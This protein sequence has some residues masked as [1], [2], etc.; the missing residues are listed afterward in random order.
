MGASWCNARAL[1]LMKH[2]GVNLVMDQM[3]SAGYVG[4]VGGFVLVEAED[5][6][7]WSSQVEQDNRYL[8]EMSYI[9]MLEPSSAQEAKDMVKDAFQLSEDYKQ[10]FIIRSTTRVG[11]ARGDVKLGEIRKT[12][13][14]TS[15]TKDPT[16][17]ILLPANSRKL[18]KAM[19]ERLAGIKEAVNT[20]KYNALVLKPGAKLGLITGGIA[21]DKNFVS[22]IQEHVDK[23]APVHVFPGEDEMRALAMNG[24]LPI[25]G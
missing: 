5:P 22:F 10:P 9:P 23:I 24:L 12:K 14:P 21:Y 19:V 25:K 13:N 7:Q 4:A 15:F 1:A 3:T 6:G 8:A 16:R 18:R 11:H 20:W 2:V 17:F